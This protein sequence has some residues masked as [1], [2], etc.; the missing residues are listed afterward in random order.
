ME[1]APNLTSVFQ[2][3]EVYCYSAITAEYAKSQGTMRAS[4]CVNFPH[5]KSVEIRVS[6]GQ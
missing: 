5:I 6:Q 2:T 3:Y 4:K 1:Q